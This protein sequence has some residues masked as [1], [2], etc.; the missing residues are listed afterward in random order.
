MPGWQE[1]INFL[2]NS[3]V[4]LRFPPQTGIGLAGKRQFEKRFRYD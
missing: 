1:I 2:F 3:G 4:A